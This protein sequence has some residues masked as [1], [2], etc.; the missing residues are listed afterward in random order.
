MI[1]KVNEFDIKET[2]N[3]KASTEAGFK[4]ITENLKGVRRQDLSEEALL[5]ISEL[6]QSRFI[7]N[8][9]KDGKTIGEITFGESDAKPVIGIEIEEPFRNRGIGYMVLKE[10]M[11]R[12]STEGEEYF[13]YAVRNDNIPSV[14]LV[15]KLGG[16]R[17]RAVKLMDKYDLEIF[18]YHIS[19]QRR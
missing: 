6:T 1:F 11:M 5:R 13:V 10:L 8:I 3:D 7:Y 16:V 15:E 17:V 14:R 4:F 9:S 12:R 18:T 2:I 19:P